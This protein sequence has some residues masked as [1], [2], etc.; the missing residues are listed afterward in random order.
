ME[1]HAPL[2]GQMVF[3]STLFVPTFLIVF[4]RVCEPISGTYNLLKEER[5]TEKKTPPQK[6]K[7]LL[8]F[9]M[10]VSTAQSI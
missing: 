1:K 6:K 3:I 5:R 7:S 10:C 2:F 9:Y 4:P 8:T